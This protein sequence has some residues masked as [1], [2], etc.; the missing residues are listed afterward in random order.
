MN[1]SIVKLKGEEWEDV[2][3]FFTKGGYEETTKFNKKLLIMNKVNKEIPHKIRN[4]ETQKKYVIE[5]ME[6]YLMKYDL[7]DLLDVYIKI[8]EDS[9]KNT[10]DIQ[11]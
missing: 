6:K 1:K 7:L 5:R 11:N 9:I 10:L 3:S 4:E 8:K 2:I